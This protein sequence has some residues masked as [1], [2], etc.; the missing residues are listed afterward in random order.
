MG[1]ET[2]LAASMARRT[3]S[4]SMVWFFPDTAIT[5]RELKPRMWVPAIPT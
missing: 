4:R 3:S 2:A 5:P 1:M